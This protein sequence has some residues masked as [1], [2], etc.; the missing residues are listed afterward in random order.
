MQWR[1]RY[2]LASLPSPP[3]PTTLSVS[4]SKKYISHLKHHPTFLACYPYPISQS[5]FFPL[6]PALDN[7]FDAEINNSRWKGT[8]THKT[9]KSGGSNKVQIE[10]VFQRCESRKQKK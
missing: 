5:L 2:L 3:P 4:H 10:G 8:V 9:S 1:I 6:S 7:S